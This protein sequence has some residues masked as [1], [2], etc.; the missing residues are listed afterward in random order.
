MLQ[1]NVGLYTKAGFSK[2]GKSD[3]VHGKDTWLEFELVLNADAAAPPKRARDECCC[4][5]WF[6]SEASQ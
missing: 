6:K 5:S 2:V 3:V 1:K 4:A